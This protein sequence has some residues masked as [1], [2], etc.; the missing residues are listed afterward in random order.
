MTVD[1]FGGWLF[2]P[3]VI[4]KKELVGLQ[5]GKAIFRK[6]RRVK[7]ARLSL[8]LAEAQHAKAGIADFIAKHSLT[9]D[10]RIDPDTLLRTFSLKPGGFT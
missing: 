8:K 10:A 9:P 6:L 4:G 1:D 3:E 5:K 7:D 2:A